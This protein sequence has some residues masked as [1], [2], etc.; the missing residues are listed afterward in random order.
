MTGPLNIDTDRLTSY[1]DK[2]TTE[3]ED[4]KGVPFQD[5]LKS[6]IGQVNDL[7]LNMDRKIDQFASGE[8]KDLHEVMIAV[9]EAD[10]AFQLMMEIRN[11]LMTAFEDV[12]KMQ[13]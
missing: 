10:I 6:F 1:A 3:L 12:M 2:L 5:V 13:V 7:Q 11:K 9:E 8:I 4:R